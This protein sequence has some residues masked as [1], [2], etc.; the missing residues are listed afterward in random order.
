MDAPKHLWIRYDPGSYV[1]S[2]SPFLR[3]TKYLCADL[4][5]ELRAAAVKHAKVHDPGCPAVADDESDYEFLDDAGE[6]VCSARDLRN[7]LAALVEVCDD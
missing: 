2:S 5:E 6:C 4:V 3:S 7:A 1:I